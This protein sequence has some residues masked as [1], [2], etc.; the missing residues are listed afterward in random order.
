MLF[1]KKELIIISVGKIACLNN[2][3]WFVLFLQC[4]PCKGA[5]S[6]VPIGRT[7]KT[8][9][10][11][12]TRL[13]NKLL[14]VANPRDIGPILAAEIS[15]NDH[16]CSLVNQLIYVCEHLREHGHWNNAYAIVQHRG[17]NTPDSKYETNSDLD[18]SGFDQ[19]IQNLINLLLSVRTYFS[20]VALQGPFNP[21]PP[22]VPRNEYG[23]VLCANI[24]NHD[25]GKLLSPSGKHKVTDTN[26]IRIAFRF[27]DRIR[28]DLGPL[29]LPNLQVIIVTMFPENPASNS[30]KNSILP[31]GV[32]AAGNPLGVAVGALPPPHAPDKR[33]PAV[34]SAALATP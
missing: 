33:I 13:R 34:A 22:E 9:Q 11:L 19:V 27:M 15:N 28:M 12:A 25:I 6:Y 17:K 3:F 21:L 23:F 16:R 7:G 29:G 2:I 20:V 31:N 5:G 24:D 4:F 10:A 14:R 26:Y 30:L 1:G 32:D 8:S 18:V